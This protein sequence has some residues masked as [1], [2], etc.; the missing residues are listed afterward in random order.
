MKIRFV[1]TSHGAAEKGAKCT[2]VIVEINQNYYI[3]DTGAC[4][5][6]YMKENGLNTAD[7]KGVFIT[8]MHEDHVGKISSLLKQMTTYNTNISATFVFPEDTAPANVEAWANTLHSRP[9]DHQRLPFNVAKD[10]KVVYKDNNV[11]ITAIKTDHINGFDT[12][13]YMF[14]TADKRVVFTGDLTPD[15]HDY[16]EIIL[17]EGCD[18]VVTELC[19]YFKLTHFME[20]TIEKLKQ[21]KTKQMIFSHKYPGGAEAMLKQKDSFNFPIH[22]VNDNDIIEI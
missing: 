18:L 1:G 4:A 5:V 14:E 17:N 12:Y 8:H 3:I 9:I 6:E 19:H 11:T 22:I 15:L 2:C 10:G 20:G 13:G 21:S 7:I 16:P